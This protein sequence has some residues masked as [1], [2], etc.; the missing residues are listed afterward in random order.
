MDKIAKHIAVEDPTEQAFRSIKFG[1]CHA[2]SEFGLTPKNAEELL[3]KV[4]KVDPVDL[5]KSY[6]LLLGAT[7]VAAGLGTA[8]LRHK[9]EQ[10][11]SNAET[12]EMRASNAKITAYKKMIENLKEED[13]LKKQQLAASAGAA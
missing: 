11:G 3:E 8:A 13:R 6:T 12:P 4:A 9:I 1:L 10:T 2:M 7:G 5:L